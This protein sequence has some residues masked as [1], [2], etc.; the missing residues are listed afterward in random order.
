MNQLRVEWEAREPP[1]PPAAVVAIGEVLPALARSTL[2]SLDGDS[3]SLTASVGASCLVIIG[4][5]R[6]LPWADGAFYLGW[7]TGMLMPTLARPRLPADLVVGAIRRSIAV[8]SGEQIAYWAETVLVIPRSE[9]TIDR[10]RL[11]AL[12]ERVP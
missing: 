5:A 9:T 6:E 8:G 1:L 11:E 7:D 12:A 2:R 3:K 10:G 4:E